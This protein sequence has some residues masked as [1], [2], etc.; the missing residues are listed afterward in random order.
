M[1]VSYLN[2]LRAQQRPIGRFAK[3]PKET[4]S[5]AEMVA[6]HRK[7]QAAL[8]IA[9]RKSVVSVKYAPREMQERAAAL[10]PAKPIVLVVTAEQF[11]QADDLTPI[12]PMPSWKTIVREVSLKHG[13]SII[14]MLSARRSKPFVYARH[15][16]M[17]RMRHETTLS[18]PQ[19]G[20]R[21]GGR[22]HT[23]VLHGIRCH[24]KRL[25]EASSQ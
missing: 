12:V 18:F 1:T 7:A 10:V 3:L 8:G 16:A 22:D 21:L 25:V 20:R 13:V 24:E 5:I 2:L 4:L 19:I 14:D 23:T 6:R 15:E 17:Y 11:S 9:P